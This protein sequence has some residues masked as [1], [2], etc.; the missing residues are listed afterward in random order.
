ML[1]RVFE[2]GNQSLIF[3]EVIGLVAEV[4]A[5]RGDL[6]SGFILDDDSIPGRT[7]IAARP[8]ITVGDQVM[9]G[10]ILASLEKMFGS[11]CGRNQKACSSL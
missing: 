10:R 8:A 1:N 11:C 5:E 9:L 7:R 3:R 6:P 4:F 2:R